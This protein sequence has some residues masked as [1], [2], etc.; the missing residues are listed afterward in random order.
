MKK[1]VLFCLVGLVAGGAGFAASATNGVLNCETDA[2]VAKV[3]QASNAVAKCASDGARQNAAEAVEIK[4][5]ECVFKFV[6]IDG[7]SELPLRHMHTGGDDRGTKKVRLP[8]YWIASA[9]ISRRQFAEVMGTAAVP[10][11][12]AADA[13]IDNIDWLTAYDFCKRF[14]ERYADQLPKGYLLQLPTTIEWAHAIR[15][16][17]KSAKV[18]NPVGCLLFTGEWCGG[19]LR[20]AN[21]EEAARM[22]REGNS[23]FDAAVDYLCISMREKCEG[24]GMRPVLSPIVGGDGEGDARM[25]TRGIILTQ[26][27]R[28][29]EAKRVLKLAIEKGDLDDEQMER[30]E[31]CLEYLDQE[32]AEDFEDWFGLVTL[33]AEFAARQGYATEPY[34]ARWGRRR[35]WKMED[36]DIAAAYEKVGIEGSFMRIGDLPAEARRLQHVGEKGDMTIFVGEALGSGS[37]SI[38]SNT[39]VQVLKCDFNGDGK[40]DLVVEEFDAVGSYGYYY[41]FF[42]QTPSGSYTNILN[43]QT[44]GLCAIPSTNGTSCAFI[45]VAKVS[46]PVLSTSL[47]TYQDGKMRFEEANE[48]SFCLTDAKED[49]IYS[50]APFIGGGLGLGWSHLRAKGFWYRPLFWPWKPGTIQDW[51]RMYAEAKREVESEQSEAQETE[52]EDKES[53]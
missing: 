6:A 41:N 37:Y 44:V 42:L 2:D 12:N 46:N 29:G 10:D 39:L 52:N 9:P 28:W 49:F 21:D 8:R 47:I 4:S 5:K 32:H 16:L 26:H 25:V 50:A 31:D 15:V 19:F 11:K 33:S 3:A 27:G 36:K 14:N 53:E 48:R 45:H 13:P 43:L 40:Q 30:A 22:R 20:A 34:A 51:D 1:L 17:E 18:V 38:T 7:E 24:F 23:A 35:L